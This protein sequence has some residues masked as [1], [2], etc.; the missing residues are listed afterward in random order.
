[1]LDDSEYVR[2]NV[3]DSIAESSGLVVL[4]LVGRNDGLFDVYRAKRGRL[5]EAVESGLSEEQARQWW[6]KPLAEMFR[7][8]TTDP[9]E[10]AMLISGRIESLFRRAAGRKT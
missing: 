5:P 6:A 3:L 7:Q 4:Q 8:M 2:S 9:D 10:L 1:M